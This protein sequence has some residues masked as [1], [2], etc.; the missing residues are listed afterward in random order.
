M[1]AD[2]MQMPCAIRSTVNVVRSGA[3]ASSAVG[4]D[5]KARLARIPNRRSMRWLNTETINPAAAMPMVLAL[6]AKPMAAGVT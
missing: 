1:K 6:T 4:I 3:I 2:A 5:S